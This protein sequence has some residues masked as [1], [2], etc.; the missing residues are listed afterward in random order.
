MACKCN[1]NASPVFIWKTGNSYRAVPARDITWKIQEKN[2]HYSILAC[3]RS[4]SCLNRLGRV[5]R[6]RYCTE[7]VI[8]GSHD[9]RINIWSTWCHLDTYSN[10]TKIQ[11]YRTDVH[12]V[13][14][15]HWNWILVRGLSNK[16]R[17]AFNCIS[18]SYAY[19]W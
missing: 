3:C 5:P 15:D 2:I 4:S 11:D 14:I 17:S 18:F 13:C 16:T 10:N 19:T 7:F 12:V 8:W 1:G 6:D 9:L